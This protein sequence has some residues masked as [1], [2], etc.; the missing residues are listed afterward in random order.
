M[1]QGHRQELITLEQ[2]IAGKSS[3]I[4]HL[5]KTVGE[6]TLANDQLKNSNT[7][8]AY[9]IGELEWRLGK[10]EQ[11]V[12]DRN[13]KIDAMRGTYAWKLSAPLR[14]LETFLKKLLR[15]KPHG[16]SK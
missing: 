4:E 5:E 2:V 6:Q 11:E 7:E 1:Q 12:I 14:R 13:R 9:R 3:I 10:R 16:L 15:S 8:Q